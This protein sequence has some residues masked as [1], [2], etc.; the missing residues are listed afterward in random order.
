M[1]YFGGIFCMFN[2]FLFS[3]VVTKSYY[4]DASE[5]I[6][7]TIANLTWNVY[8]AL[9][10]IAVIRATTGVS[11]EEKNALKQIYK[12]VNTSMDGKLSGRVGVIAF[13]LSN[14]G[15][16]LSFFLCFFS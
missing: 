3:L 1:L 10:V 12:I 15:L 6:A 9:I 2:L 11:A 8:D 4:E 14:G 16:K 13:L 7:M 5:A